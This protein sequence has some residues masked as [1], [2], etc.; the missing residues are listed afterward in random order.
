MTKDWRKLFWLT[1]VYVVL[2]AASVVQW[3]VMP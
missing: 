2:V 3:W 1:V